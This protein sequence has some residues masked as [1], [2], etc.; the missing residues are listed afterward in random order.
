[1]KVAGV[2]LSS[3]AVRCY[4]FQTVAHTSM[5]R[6][7][8]NPGDF[9]LCKHYTH[10]PRTEGR[11]R[12]E[13]Q[14]YE[15]EQQLWKRLS[16]SS[17]WNHTQTC[18]VII[19]CAC[20]SLLALA[21]SHDITHQWLDHESDDSMTRIFVLVRCFWNESGKWIMR[22]LILGKFLMV[23][24]WNGGFVGAWKMKSATWNEENVLKDV[25]DS[26]MEA[27][28]VQNSLIEAFEV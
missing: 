24:A 22:R 25:F 4:Y 12:K 1:M 8:I 19:S 6:R 17:L 26:L 20:H 2:L 5:T 10:V 18:F 15:T 13:L 7:V 9:F 16:N 11:E 28:K 3:G 14:H 27:F 21:Y 23:L